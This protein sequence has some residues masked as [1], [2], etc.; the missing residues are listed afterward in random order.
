M[1]LPIVQLPPINCTECAACCKCLILRMKPGLNADDKRFLE[2]RPQIELGSDYIALPARC[3]H[4]EGQLCS[5][6]ARRPIACRVFAK[7][8]NDCKVA[9]WFM[10]PPPKLT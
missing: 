10:G 7:D 1:P 6:Y 9:R 5:I 8:S 2:T 4:L 3:K